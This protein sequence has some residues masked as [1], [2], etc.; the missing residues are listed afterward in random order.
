MRA[1][2]LFWLLILPIHVFAQRDLTPYVNPF[3]GTGG[4]GHTFP[5]AIVPF[6]MVQLSP[7]TRLTGWDGCSGYH[8]SDSKI[9]GFSH[10]HLSGTGIS[11]YGDILLMPTLGKEPSGRFQH[12][13]ET[14]TPG[15]YSVKLD[16]DAIFV[17][18]TTTARVGFHRYTFPKTEAATIRIDLGHRDKV[19]DSDLRIT[20]DTTI[21][22]WRRSQ[23][24]AKDQVVY[25]AAEFSQPFTSYRWINDHLRTNLRFD[26]RGGAPILVKVGIS[27]VD[28]EG[29]LKNLHAELNHWDFDK[30]RSD[31]AAAWN[32][33][34]NKIAVNGG[35]NA[36]LTNFYT[37]MYHAMTA[38]NLFMDVDG[39]YR[40]RDFKIHKAADFSNYT[41]FS[42]WDTFRA[43]HP[44]YN[45]IDQKRSRD[46]IRTFLTQYEQGGRLPV[47][48][49]AAN[50]TDT[51]IGYHAVSVIADAAVKGIDGFELNKAFEA[52]KHSAEFRQ[53]RGLGAYID[54]GFIAM[55]EERESVSKVLEYAYDDWCIAEVAR[56]LGKTEDYERYS[57]RAQSYKNVFD[58]ATGFMRPRSNGNWLD[59]FDPREVT[60]GFTEAN[61]W[62]Y[63]FFAPQD[64]SGLIA[65]MGGRRR[66]AERL[67]Q[68]F[69]AD[70]RTTGREQVDIT[71]L[72]GQYA[73]GNEPS[74]HMAYLYNY[75]SQPWKT[76]ARVRQIMDQFYKP[77]PDGLIGNEDCGQMSAWYV[78]S[79]AG[80]YPV[81]PGS[82]IYAIGS[83]LFPEMRFNLENGNS[84]VVRAVGMS[85]NNIYIQSATLNGRPY[86]KSF[87]MHRD[88]MAGGE[89]V[90]R[91]G[92]RP[93]LRWGTGTGNEPVSRIAGREIV[94]VPVIKGAGQTFIR[95]QEISLAPIGDTPVKLYYTLDG[96]QPSIHSRRFEKSFF[97]DAD[98]T[99]KALAVAPDGRR[100]LIVSASYHRMPHAWKLSLQSN[101][102]SQYTGGGE[103]AL[104]DGI[105]GTTNWSGGAWQ[106]YQGR[107]LVA[108][109]DLGEAQTVSRI[110]AGFLQDIG[111]WI[112]MPSRVE[113]ELSKDGETFGPAFSIAND[114]S[115]K[116]EGVVTKEFV[117]PITPQTAR[118][119]RIRAVNFGKILAWH[120]GSGG[121]AWIFA[122]E[123]VV[124]K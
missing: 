39:R 4:H 57:A 97:I 3:I 118:Y 74:H 33:E 48:E 55:E 100:S 15:Y 114:V 1:I 82:A 66:F 51:M 62:Q 72:I 40:G 120:P 107:D 41:V 90:F 73:H 52:M 76:Q 13:N 30:V 31:A 84:F 46:F 116:M 106:G 99:V 102:S 65:L 23:A 95:R 18:L 64:V 83:P 96:S 56:M 92:P 123:I 61:S 17:E 5:G 28:I 20:S 6:G 121:D 58:S 54:H 117:I 122:D 110:G 29:A 42:L 89:L 101:Y 45:I 7:D 104:I 86:N 115:V 81:T 12:R 77:D 103:L 24:W 35:T 34:L 25:F 16:D 38:P 71:G 93:N 21:V 111:S 49:L 113:V 36:Q 27:S 11:D 47:W 69:A 67:D 10:T 32:R 78:L 79:A 68:L 53:H 26:A 105:R 94:P 80:F 87:L 75:V 8:Y 22:G 112:W 59:P 19:I 108:V 88:L 63:T 70:S 9:Y 60:F 124:E 98:T 14:A 37:A 109:L 85:E 91:M 44:L 119:V 2:I 50:E 43:A